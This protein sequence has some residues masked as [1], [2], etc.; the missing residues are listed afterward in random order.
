MINERHIE[1]LMKNKEKYYGNKERMTSI[2]KSC[3]EFKKFV[4]IE[5]RLKEKYNCLYVYVADHYED[6]GAHMLSC[7]MITN[8]LKY[9]SLE[10]INMSNFY[11]K[12]PSTL[13]DNYLKIDKEVI[14]DEFVYKFRFKEF[15]E[16]TISYCKML[17]DITLKEVELLNKLK[18]IEL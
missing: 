15:I 6:N 2:D 11:K 16:R 8:D 4:E 18:I 3:C 12:S 1:R 17:D 10:D 13:C 9:I 5:N 7:Q 14:E